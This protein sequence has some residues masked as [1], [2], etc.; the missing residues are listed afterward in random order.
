MGSKMRLTLGKKLG[1]GFGVVLAL[2]VFT[3]VLGC[4]K[5][6]VAQGYDKGIITLRFPTQLHN[7]TLV[8]LLTQ[9]QSKEREYILLADDP[10]VAQRARQDWEKTWISIDAEV[11]AL[12]ELSSQFTIQDSKDEV[13]QIRNGLADLRRIQE[14]CFQVRQPNQNE[15]ILAAAHCMIPA[16]GAIDK[17]RVAMGG[18]DNNTQ[19]LMKAE[20]EKLVSAIGAIYK[21]LIW[22]TV[23]A[24]GLGFFIAISLGRKIT[25]AIGEVLT[26]SE[27]IASHD[28]SGA[29]LQV[30]SEDEIGDLFRAVNKM[31]LSL[32]GIV[33]EV[34]TSAEH[35]ASASEEISASAS[36]Q[37]H[38]ASLQ[39][40]QTRQMATAMHEMSVTVQEISENSNAAAQASNKASETAHGGG[41]VVGQTLEIMRVI[42][43]SVTETASKIEELGKGSERIG[44]IIGVIDDIADQ[45]NLLALNAAIEAARAGEQGRGFAVVA[46]EVRKLAERTSS[47]TKEITAMIEEIQKETAHAVEAMKAGTKHVELG[48]QSTQEAGKSLQEIIGASDKVGEMVTHIATAATE[49]ASATDEVNRNVEQ[50]STITADTAKGAEQ[51]AVACQELSDLALNLNNLVGRFTLGRK[52]QF[53][54][55]HAGSGVRRPAQ[56]FDHR[57]N[58]SAYDPREESSFVN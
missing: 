15:T 8:F 18:I 46:D 24:V 2:M 25:S 41:K 14:S 17:I 51:S 12:T 35:L 3:A 27:A 57:D 39:K 1:L 16:N 33:N 52:E 21:A 19:T 9:S 11:Q 4:Y 54:R 32:S 20:M 55:N 31:Q 45:T 36:Q 6:S 30:R 34:A 22:S 47:A 56:G 48:V 53:A 23:L 7:K 28:L 44:K 49:Q 29:E 10:A 50:I 42:A 26:R 13:T 5:I 58:S 37:S 43:S 38:G 40:D